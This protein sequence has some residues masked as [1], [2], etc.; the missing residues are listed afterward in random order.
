MEILRKKP[1]VLRVILILTQY[2]FQASCFGNILVPKSQAYPHKFKVY[3][4][5]LRGNWQVVSIFLNT[6]PTF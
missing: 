4:L 3:T 2:L 1:I 6:G 5:A